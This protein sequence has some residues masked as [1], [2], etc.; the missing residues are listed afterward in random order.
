MNFQY[1]LKEIENDIRHEY[2]QAGKNLQRLPRLPQSVGRK[3]DLML[4]I[5][6]LKYHP[7]ELFELPNG[8]RIYKSQFS[9][10]DSADSRGVVGGPHRIFTAIDRKRDHMLALLRTYLTWHEPINT[11]SK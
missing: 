5:L 3:T 4:G 2:A 9:S 10:A 7:K 1:P 6:Y 8:L 11:D